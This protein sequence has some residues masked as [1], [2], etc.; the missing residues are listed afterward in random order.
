M[1]INRKCNNNNDDEDDKN[2]DDIYRGSL[3]IMTM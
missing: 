2:D 1:M 3:T